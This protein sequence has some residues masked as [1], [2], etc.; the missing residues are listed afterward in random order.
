MCTIFIICKVGYE[1]IQVCVCVK[2]YVIYIFGYVI[3][4]WVHTQAYR[5]ICIGLI[6]SL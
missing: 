3:Y 4:I 1:C 5:Y 2:I 6:S